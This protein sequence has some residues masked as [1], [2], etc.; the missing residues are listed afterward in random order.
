MHT[1]RRDIIELCV[2]QL[3]SFKHSRRKIV[4]LQQKTMYF[5]LK[6]FTR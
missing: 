6:E 2:I 5:F 1:L 4:L 3:H